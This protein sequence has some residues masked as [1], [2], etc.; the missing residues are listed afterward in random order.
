MGAIS[1]AVKPNLDV[2]N[3]DRLKTVRRSDERNRLTLIF[4]LSVGRCSHVIFRQNPLKQGVIVPDVGVHH[5]LQQT[6]ESCSSAAGSD[7]LRE[8]TATSKGR[9]PSN[10]G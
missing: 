6:P 8:L 4:K 3:V 2:I 7:E 9:G 1:V 5:L 10:L